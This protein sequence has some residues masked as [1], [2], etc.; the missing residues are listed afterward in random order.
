MQLVA[1]KRGLAVMKMVQL[2]D[3]W[4]IKT[5]SL[6]ETTVSTWTAMTNHNECAHKPTYSHPA[7]PLCVTSP[8]SPSFLPLCVSC[9][10]ELWWGQSSRHAENDFDLCPLSSA[11]AVLHGGAG[12]QRSPPFT[13]GVGRPTASSSQTNG[14]SAGLKFFLLWSL[15]CIIYL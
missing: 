5:E 10:C 8:L 2:E 14:L 6:E 13:N 9:W 3:Y 12:T 15:R 4:L 1:P 7:T 11:M